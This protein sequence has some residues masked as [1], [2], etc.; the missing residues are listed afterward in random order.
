V[1]PRFPWASSVA[2]SPDGATLA[3][4]GISIFFWDLEADDESSSPSSIADLNTQAATSLMCSPNGIFP[5]SVGGVVKTWRAS[6]GSLCKILRDHYF[7]SASFPPNG[8]LVAD[9]VRLSTTN[10]RHTNYLAIWLCLHT[11]ITMTMRTAKG[12]KQ[13]LELTWSLLLPMDKSSRPGANKTVISLSGTLESSCR[14]LV[15][16]AC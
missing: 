11:P 8:K 7:L 16:T 3:A 10:D 6:D 1:N 15:I 13:Q 9:A 4:A 12:R 5:A 14:A 2:F